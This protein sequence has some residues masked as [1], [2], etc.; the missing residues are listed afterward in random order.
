[1]GSEHQKMLGWLRPIGLAKGYF[2]PSKK[3]LPQTMNKKTS[4]LQKRILKT[5]YLKGKYEDLVS[6]VE[7]NPEKVN[8]EY[9]LEKQK[10]VD[11]QK[12]S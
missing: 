1:M 3:E 11:E 4:R 6:I 9:Q 12:V 2:F 10:L 5:I 8:V 7:L